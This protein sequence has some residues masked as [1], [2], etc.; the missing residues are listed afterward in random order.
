MKKLELILLEYEP[1]SKLILSKIWKNLI[2]G[3]IGNKYILG[4]WSRK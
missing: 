4:R 2:D 3:K 1:K